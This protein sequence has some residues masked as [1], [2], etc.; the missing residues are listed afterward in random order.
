M[1]ENQTTMTIEIE[2]ELYAQASELF[3]SRGTTIEDMAAAFIRF[4]VVPE[5]LPLLKAFL[6]IENTP[7]EAGARM[8]LEHQVF[9]K[10]FDIAAKQTER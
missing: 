1:N 6:D 5:N 4:C 3:Q 8:E 2:P 7:A 10:V 9:R